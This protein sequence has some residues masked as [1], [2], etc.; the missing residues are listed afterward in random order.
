MTVKPCASGNASSGTGALALLAIVG[1]VV[2]AVIFVVQVQALPALHDPLDLRMGHYTS[3]K[4][5][6]QAENARAIIKDPRSD[7]GYHT[8]N[9]TS[10]STLRVC[11]GK[12]GDAVVWAVQWVTC[13]LNECLDWEWQ[14]GT[15]FIQ[16]RKHK[17][18]NY[19]RNNGCNDPERE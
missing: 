18:D 10:G 7:C 14:E 12:L 6:T 13:Q 5:A 4:R 15:S 16:K 1:I 9:T 2:L 17:L 11:R 3:W 19:R 8:C